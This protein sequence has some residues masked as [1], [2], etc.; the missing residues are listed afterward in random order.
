M[1]IR[2]LTDEQG[3]YL[4]TWESDKVKYSNVVDSEDLPESSLI[5]PHERLRSLVI[6]PDGVLSTQDSSSY[7]FLLTEPDNNSSPALF[8][9]LLDHS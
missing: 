9:K 1:E 4:M 7:L 2:E 3:Q 8:L 6:S 5:V